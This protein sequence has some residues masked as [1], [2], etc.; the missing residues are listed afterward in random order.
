VFRNITFTGTHKAAAGTVTF[1]VHGWTKNPLVE[2][3]IIEDYTNANQYA[4][5]GSKGTVTCDGS[6]YTIY[7]TTRTTRLQSSDLD[8]PPVH[9]RPQNEE[10]ELSQYRGKSFRRVEKSWHELGG[11]RLPGPINRRL[12]Q[13]SWI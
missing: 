12:Q 1:Q 11:T 7:E 3:H 5:D 13:C 2:Y 8:L 4:C 9:F 6:D 10:T